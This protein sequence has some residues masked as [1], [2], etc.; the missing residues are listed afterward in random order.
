MRWCLDGTAKVDASAT[1]HFILGMMD[2]GTHLNL[3]LAR[4]ESATSESIL[5]QL[6]S[7]IRMFGK[8]KLIRTDNASVFRSSKLKKVMSRLGIRQEF[9]KPGKPWQNGS[10][11]RL[12]LTLKEKLN[13]ITPVNVWLDARLFAGRFYGLV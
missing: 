5:E 1:Q 12:F 13:L 7:A 2:H 8:P 3:L 4:L 10:I 6:A 9:S 11:K